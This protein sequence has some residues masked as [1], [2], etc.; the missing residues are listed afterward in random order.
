MSYLTRIR[1][2]KHSVSNENR[3]R[4]PPLAPAGGEGSGVRGQS[5]LKLPQRTAA[6]RLTRIREVNNLSPLATGY[7]LLATGYWLL[8]TEHRKPKTEPL[9]RN[10]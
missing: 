6:A 8:K 10:P 2:G 9:P 3:K 5:T 7:W 1:E 4:N